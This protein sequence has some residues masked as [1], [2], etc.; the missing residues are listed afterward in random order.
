MKNSLYIYQN[1]E[2]SRKDNTLRFTG[3]EGG[4]RIYLLTV[5]Q[6]FIFSE[7]IQ[8]IPSLSLFWHRII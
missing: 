8:S 2:L 7:K 6:R 5:F 3:E 4:K 1:G